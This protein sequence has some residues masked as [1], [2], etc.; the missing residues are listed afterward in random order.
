VSRHRCPAQ[1]GIQYAAAFEG[2][3]NCHGVLHHPL[4]RMMTVVDVHG[5]ADSKPDR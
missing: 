2:N 3:N 5:A 1:A 4:S